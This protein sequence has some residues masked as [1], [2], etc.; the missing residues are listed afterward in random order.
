MVPSGVPAAKR[1]SPWRRAFFSPRASCIVLQE[2][3]EKSLRYGYVGR[4]LKKRDF[5]SL[6]IVRI[7]AACRQGEISY[8]RF[9]SGL[10]KAGIDLNRK[11]LADMA[12]NEPGAFGALVTQAKAALESA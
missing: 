10:K 6:W 3:V 1:R 5:R 8:S 4:R 9:M 7:G 2:A 11:I 12:M